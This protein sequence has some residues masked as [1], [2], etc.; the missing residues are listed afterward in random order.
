MN[1][2]AKYAAWKCRKKTRRS[3]KGIAALEFALT[4]PVW[5]TLMLGVCDGTYCLLVNEKVNRIAYTV[6]DIVT[7]YQDPMTLA[8]LNDTTSAASQLMLPY[9]FG[10]QGIVIVSSVYKPTGQSPMIEWQ[11]VGG[12]S[13]VQSSKIG[14]T[15][16]AATL[17]NGLTMND[18]DCVIVTEVY[19]QFTPMFLSDSLFPSS[20]IYDVAM[21]KP[22]L[23]PLLTTPS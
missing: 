8:I 2:I 10:A 15:G 5:V 12:G 22:R 4:L 1:L 13:M 7:Q 14:S 9:S 17:P 21:Y 20:L 18:G 16:G 3:E 19:Y 11:Y 23:G 6:S